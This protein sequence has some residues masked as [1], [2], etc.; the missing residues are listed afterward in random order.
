MRG[1]VIFT[2][3][4][5]PGNAKLTASELPEIIQLTGPDGQPLP[6]ESIEGEAYTCST[7]NCNSAVSLQFSS[8]LCALLIFAAV[9]VKK[10]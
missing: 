5:D 4:N 3:D 9:M 1:C 8:V 7:D 6:L 2:R 10:L